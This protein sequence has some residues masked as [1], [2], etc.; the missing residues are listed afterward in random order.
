M[1]RRIL[2]ELEQHGSRRKEHVECSNQLGCEVADITGEADVFNAHTKIFKTPDGLRSAC[3]I[4]ISTYVKT[5]EHEESVVEL[6]NNKRAKL[7]MVE[8][9][10]HVVDEA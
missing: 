5:L 2:V 6:I 4:I 3:I 8:I 9:R 7:G 10:F 1:R